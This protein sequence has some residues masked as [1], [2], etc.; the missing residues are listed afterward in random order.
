[1]DVYKDS[2]TCDKLIFPLAIM[3]LLHHFDVPFPSSNPFHVIGAIDDSTVKRSKVQLH[4]RWS[5]SIATLTPSIPST[6]APFSSAS[7]MTLDTIMAQLHHMDAHLDTLT[8][9]LC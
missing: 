3:R 9:E 8:D 5:G 6:S 4:S 1:M 7:G 2:T